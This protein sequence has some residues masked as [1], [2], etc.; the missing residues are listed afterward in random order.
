VT[1]RVGADVLAAGSFAALSGLKGMPKNASLVIAGSLNLVDSVA[2]GLFLFCFFFFCF[3][4]VLLLVSTNSRWSQI[5][6]FGCYWSESAL[7]ARIF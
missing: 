1:V 4:C 7:F 2:R 3:L 5:V 6:Q